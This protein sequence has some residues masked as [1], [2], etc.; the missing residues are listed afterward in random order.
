M[1]RGRG[2][3]HDR[4]TDG[5]DRPTGP[6]SVRLQPPHARW[7][8]QP[9]QPVRTSVDGDREQGDEQRRTDEFDV[10][11]AASKSVSAAPTVME[12]GPFQ[13]SHMLRTFHSRSSVAVVTMVTPLV[14]P[15]RS[16][17][18]VGD[19]SGGGGRLARFLRRSHSA[20]L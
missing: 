17:R 8:E 1:L 18:A 6:G 10:T 19:G 4:H 13:R 2:R 12:T 16:Q 3:P 15:W 9:R 7:D 20:W 11:A 14:K 5:P